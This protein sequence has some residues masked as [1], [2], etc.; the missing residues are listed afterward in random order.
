[1]MMMI[2]K[3]FSRLLQASPHLG[4][5]AERRA[6]GDHQILVGDENTGKCKTE[7][8]NYLRVSMDLFLLATSQGW[9]AKEVEL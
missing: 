5:F 8:T 7:G 6:V 9:A 4:F 3:D 2:Q 1:M